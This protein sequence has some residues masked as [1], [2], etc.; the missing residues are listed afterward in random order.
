MRK[1][2]TLTV[3]II[4]LTAILAASAA[5]AGQA[6]RREGRQRARIH[7]GVASGELTPGETQK[8]KRE[9]RHIERT[10]ERALADGKIGPKEHAKLQHE[11]NKA[12][13]DINRLKH[14][15]RQVPPA[16]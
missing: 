10:R 12:S 11:Q 7:Q 14:N 4:G 16:Q 8:L 2:I 5:N 9:Q 13:R 15:E 6:A 3:G 1:H